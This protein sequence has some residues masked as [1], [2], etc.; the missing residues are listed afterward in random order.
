[1]HVFRGHT[2][3][4]FQLGSQPVSFIIYLDIAYY[5]NTLAVK[6]SSENT[7]M[8]SGCAVVILFVLFL[9]QT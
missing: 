8:Q 1:M 4:S 2:L 7:S 5:G 3:T 9:I 6:V